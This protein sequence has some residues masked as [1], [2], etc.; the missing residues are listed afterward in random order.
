MKNHTPFTHAVC[1]EVIEHMT[2]EHGLGLLRGLYSALEAGGH[3]FISTPCYDGRR[4]AKN[5]IHEYTVPEL[6]EVIEK[7]GFAVI[8]RIGTF[9]DIKEIR[10]DRLAHDIMNKLGV[11]YDNDALS[12]MLAPAIDPDKA[13]NNFWVLKKEKEETF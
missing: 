6:R 3:A 12:C 4:H 9:A 10:T 5:H 13:R 2:T 8:K 7:A 1:F 11:Y